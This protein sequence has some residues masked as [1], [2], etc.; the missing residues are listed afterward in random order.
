MTENT[1]AIKLPLHKL[2]GSKT[3]EEIELDQNL[4]G[5]ERNDHVLYLAVKAEM[6]NRRQGTRGTKSRSMVR[7]GGRKPFRQKGRGAARVGTIRSPLWKGGGTIFGPM[8]HD[9]SMK[10]SK[11]AKRLARRVALSVKAK[12][13]SILLIE[14]FNFSEPKTK[15]MAEILKSFD[16][17]GKAALFMVKGIDSNLVKSCQ[18]IPRV[19]IRQCLNASCWDILRARHLILCKSALSELSAG[20]LDG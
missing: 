15:K 2:D 17:T 20:L 1:H 6:T 7:G 11:K 8:P 10:L 18:N 14:D 9:F 4:F 3:G 12:S 19:E 16:V 13:D 5:L